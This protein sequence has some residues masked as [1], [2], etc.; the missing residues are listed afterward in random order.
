VVIN[1]VPV[2]YGLIGGSIHGVTAFM[3]IKEFDFSL[4][5][6]LIAQR[7]VSP[8]D[9]A[10]LLVVEPTVLYDCTV[11]DLPDLLTHRD[12]L[13]F[14]NTRVI[15]TRL[16]VYRGPIKIELTLL[17]LIKADVQ[18]TTWRALARPV[19]RLKPGQKIDFPNGS[20]AKVLEKDSNGEIAFLCNSS[21]A[22]FQQ[23]LDTHATIP[24]PPYVR[25]GISDGADI[26]DYQTIF[27]TQDGAVAAPTAGLHF[28]AN[29][30]ETLN[31]RKIEHTF[32]TLHVGAG[33]FLPVRTDDIQQHILHA[34]RGFIT[35]ATAE[36]INNSRRDGG[37]IVAVGT[38]SLRL[39]ESAID[40]QGRIQPFFG[41][42]SIFITPG[43]HFRTADLLLTNFHLPCST[44]F[45]LVAAF[46]GLE[47]ARTAYQHAIE[48]RYRFY[49]YGDACLLFQNPMVL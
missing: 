1:K 30:I 6:T 11:A 32:I 31:R 22:T 49:S 2:F 35:A 43:W 23:L 3:D 17:R 4:P 8:R 18:E 33:T 19:K 14:N 40:D 27:A 24:L 20:Q 41:D 5:S 25:R 13:V 36:K 39:L 42:T 9:S 7:P 29:L 12:L 34:E 26:A 28:T 45:I 38:T 16:Q 10:R 37:R 44:L 48:Q 15:P 47:Q 21:L 46:I